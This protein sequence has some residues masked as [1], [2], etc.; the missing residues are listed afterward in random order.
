MQAYRQNNQRISVEF[1][2]ERVQVLVLL[3][4]FLGQSQCKVDTGTN[5]SSALSVDQRIRKVVGKVFTNRYYKGFF[6]VLFGKGSKTGFE[7]EK[8]NL[9]KDAVPTRVAR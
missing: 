3:V 8:M 7:G 2:S 1:F 6:G 5:S 9:L 4:C